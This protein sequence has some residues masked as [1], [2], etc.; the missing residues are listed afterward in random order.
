MPST[1]ST[2]TAGE[3]SLEMPDYL[4]TYLVIP[5][6]SRFCQQ[7]TLVNLHFSLA[8]PASV[9]IIA[10]MNAAPVNPA[11]IRR[12]ARGLPPIWQVMESYGVSQEQCLAGTGVLPSHAEGNDDGF[13]LELEHALY[14]RLL[15]LS[16]DPLLG[17]KLGACFKPEAF[18]ILGYAQMSAG[19]FGD[20]LELTCDFFE[21]TYSPFR[22]ELVRAPETVMVR[23]Q[24]AYTIPDD[25]LRVYSDRDVVAGCVIAEASKLDPSSIL[26]IHF[27]HEAMEYREIYASYFDCEIKFGQTNNAVIFDREA[28][29][30]RLPWSNE[31]AAVRCRQV[32]EEILHDIQSQGGIKAKVTN[33]LV[34]APGDYPG[35]EDVAKSLGCSTR[36]LSRKLKEENTSFQETL[37]Q[38]RL[39]FAKEYLRSGFT[40][41]RISDLLGYSEISTF[42]RAFKHWT[43]VSPQQ[44]R[45]DI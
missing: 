29:S 23:Y 1:V 36:S 27:L 21:L 20:L 45:V 9:G 31:E 8:F 35:I 11:R 39:Q 28:E 24:Q 25:L 32:C 40:I 42:S 14:R 10:A 44:Y 13:T 38:V 43:G 18:G 7:Y 30:Q 17:L 3:L 6:I 19:S 2:A 26:E 4:E 12:H 41:E 34:N 33:L 16:G 15:A 5:R 22:F 37:Q